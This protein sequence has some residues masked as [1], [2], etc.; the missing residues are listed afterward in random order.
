M[1]MEHQ[2]KYYCHHCKKMVENE[3]FNVSKKEDAY[4]NRDG[5]LP[6]CKDCNKDLGVIKKAVRD[7]IEET[8]K[9]IDNYF[10]LIHLKQL[11]LCKMFEK[12]RNK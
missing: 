8:Q 3:K 9:S 12:E 11:A 1:V 4:I 6:V 7:G 10:R 2:E 5:R